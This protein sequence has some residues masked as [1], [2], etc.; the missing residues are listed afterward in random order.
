MLDRRVAV[1]TYM[2]A[3]FQLYVCMGAAVATASSAASS[4]LRV[5]VL[6]FFCLLIVATDV[7]ETIGAMEQKPHHGKRAFRRG[8]DGA[9]VSS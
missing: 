2:Q 4:P 3:F 1:G 8:K 7:F 9:L 5:C 6:L